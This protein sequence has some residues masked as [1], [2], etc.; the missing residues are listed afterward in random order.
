MNIVHISPNAPYNDY[1]GYQEN[2][3]PKYHKRLGHNVTLII[4]N[5][6]Q[7][8]GTIREVDCADYVLNDGVRVIRKK[9]KEYCHRVITGLKS[10][11]DVYDLLV[12]LKADYVFFHGL[13]SSTIY[14][15]VKYKKKINH[16]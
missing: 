4:T 1:W 8:N 9:T 13:V 14:D 6:K 12:E 10:K 15:V 5:R 11:M 3:L 7:E 2:I 16:I